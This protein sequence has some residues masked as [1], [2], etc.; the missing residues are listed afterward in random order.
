MGDTI[1]NSS[2]YSFTS[3]SPRY[4]SFMNAKR[5]IDMKDAMGTFNIDLMHT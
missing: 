4:D 1:L 3:N 2:M 5:Q